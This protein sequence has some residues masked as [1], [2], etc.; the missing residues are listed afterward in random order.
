MGVSVSKSSQLVNAVIVV[1]RLLIFFFFFCFFFSTSTK[2][3]EEA[4][5]GFVLAEYPRVAQEYMVHHCNNTTSTVASY[6]CCAWS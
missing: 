2:E 5:M 1:L 3:G 6:H 4:Y